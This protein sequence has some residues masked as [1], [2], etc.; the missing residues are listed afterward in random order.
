MRSFDIRVAAL[1]LSVG[2][3]WID[4]LLALYPLRGIRRGRQGVQRRITEEGL[5]LIELVRMLSA[6]LGVPLRVAAK[7]AS[8]ALMEGNG[9]ELV[10][11]TPSG[12]RVSFPVDTIQTQ[13]RLR[14]Q[15]AVESAVRV[16][17]GRPPR[18][19]RDK[20]PDA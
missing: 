17:R 3:K 5:L 8:D 15:D 20:T 19:R 4:N 6:D 10:T 18:P 11:R 1:T 13:L 9:G 14:A 12:L 2:Q 7:L 16:R